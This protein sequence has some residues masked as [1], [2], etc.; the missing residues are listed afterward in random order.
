MSEVE[1]TTTKLHHQIRK[2]KRSLHARQ[3]PQ[4]LFSSFAITSGYQMADESTRELAR[5][6]PVRMASVTEITATKVYFR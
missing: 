2:G 6:E 3:L 1:T 5:I 4:V